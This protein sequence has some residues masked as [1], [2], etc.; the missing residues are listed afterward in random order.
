MALNYERIGKMVQLLRRKKGLSQTELAEK[1]DLSVSYISHIETAVKRA[2]LES[3]VR[4][5]NALDVTV[6]QL[7]NGNQTSNR[8]EYQTE[9]STLMADCNG[10]ERGVIYDVA[11]AAKM[12]MREHADLYC[13]GDAAES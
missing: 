2:S 5:A 10:F 13:R 12:S 6:D 7:L 1:T 3:L 11:V 8:G 4:I 9:L